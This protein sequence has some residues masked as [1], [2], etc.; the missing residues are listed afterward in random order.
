MKL[1]YLLLSLALIPGYSLLHGQTSLPYYSAFD[2]A[3]QQDGWEEY[4][5]GTDS[6][7]YH[8]NFASFAAYSPPHSLNH[9]YPVG[10]SERTDD[11]FVSPEFD[12]SNG[13]TIDSLRYV[14]TGFGTPMDGDTIAIYLINGSKDPETATTRTI[15]YNFTDSTYENDNVWRK[16]EALNIPATSGQSH[17]AFRYTT[18]VNWLDVRLDNLKISEKPTGIN[19]PAAINEAITIYPNPVITELTVAWNFRS[20]G[21]TITLFNMNGKVM[22]RQLIAGESQQ[23]LI[24]ETGGLKPGIYMLQVTGT[25]GRV[26]SRRFLKQ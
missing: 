4:E 8:W 3:S 19:E 20:E 1:R 15:L 17:I 22:Q 23:K 24:L 16:L 6:D 10:G 12:F 9:N 11:W 21:A 5:T 7:P 18:I 26:F 2:D 13:A 14:F 25:S